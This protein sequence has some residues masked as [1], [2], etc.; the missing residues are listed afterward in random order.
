MTFNC[1]LD[2]SYIWTQRT[3]DLLGNTINVCDIFQEDFSRWRKTTWSQKQAWQRSSR[4]GGTWVH[5]KNNP[6]LAVSRHSGEAFSSNAWN[7]CPFDR[8]SRSSA[9]RSSPLQYGTGSLKETFWGCKIICACV[10]WFP[11]TP[12][13]IFTDYNSS[14]WFLGFNVNNTYNNA[15]ETLSRCFVLFSSTTVTP[16]SKRQTFSV[17]K[18]VGF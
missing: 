15:R 14:R 10:T 2:N 16:T 8:V 4:E 18:E 5:I 13:T 12:E 3:W 9:K 1:T 11:A 17:G 7:R 6:R